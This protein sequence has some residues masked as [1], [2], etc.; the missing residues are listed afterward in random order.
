MLSADKYLTF[1]VLFLL[2][3]AAHGSD[4]GHGKPAASPEAGEHGMAT[5]TSPARELPMMGEAP[6]YALV[7]QDG[8]EF[9]SAP[10]QTA[11]K[12]LRQLIVVDAVLRHLE[13]S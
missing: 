8:K 10:A 9:D 1:F 12:H 7:S 3:L 6:E 5:D 13:G 11:M 2:A 4:H